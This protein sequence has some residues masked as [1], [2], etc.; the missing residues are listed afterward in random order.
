[1]AQINTCSGGMPGALLDQ[2]AGLVAHAAMDAQQ[3]ADD[4]GQ[5]GLPVVQDQAP[6]V[7]FVVDVRGRKR[8]EAADDAAAQRRRDVAGRRAGPKPRRGRLRRQR[9]AGQATTQNE[10][11]IS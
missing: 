11:R 2:L 1:M 7:Q 5:L 9:R 8:H 3:V 6:R 4:Q 10:I